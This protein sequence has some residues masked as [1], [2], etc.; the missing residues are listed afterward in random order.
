MTVADQEALQEQLQLH[1]QLMTQKKVTFDI[2]KEKKVFMDVQR[3]FLH[4]EEST[5]SEEVREISDLANIV[6]E[7]STK[8]YKSQVLPVKFLSANTR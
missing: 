1:V 3:E 5:T 4:P 6:E 2:Q 7:D 8:G